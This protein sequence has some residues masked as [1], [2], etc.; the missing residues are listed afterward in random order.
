MRHF[1]APVLLILFAAAWSGTAS[2]Q[3]YPSKPLKV[4]LP[5]PPGS[6]VDLSARLIG[7]KMSERLGQPIIVDNRAGGGGFIGATLV[8]RS[9]PDG[10]T[11]L[12]TSPSSLLS[13][14]VR[15][16]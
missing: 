13:V 9:A 3:A 15:S 6:T 12:F 8:A 11:L 2:S 5:F 7:T 4:V 16:G 1:L 10:Y 14:V